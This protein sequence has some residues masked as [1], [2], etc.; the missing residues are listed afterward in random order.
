MFDYQFE[1]KNSGAGKVFVTGSFD[2][3]QQINELEKQPD[4]TFMKVIQ[5]PTNEKKIIY[6]YV[7]DGNWV[8]D[9][10]KPIEDDGKGN[11]NNYI[12]IPVEVI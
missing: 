1:W 4:G 12:D 5:L 7:V 11:Q 8:I 2:N 9:N 3:W 6:K 10:S